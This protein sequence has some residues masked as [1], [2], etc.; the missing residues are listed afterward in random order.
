MRVPEN[1]LPCIEGN[2]LHLKRPARYGIVPL[3]LQLASHLHR[4]PHVAVHIH[5][6]KWLWDGKGRCYE[7]HRIAE[8]KRRGQRRGRVGRIRIRV[9]EARKVVVCFL[10]PVTEGP[11]FRERGARTGVFTQ[12]SR[13]GD[14]IKGP[15]EG[16]N[17]CGR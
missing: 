3:P 2:V 10:L 16:G 13:E 14:P 12:G 6:H 4:A 1:T 7:A 17:S 8:D 5:S 11:G 15:R 9:P